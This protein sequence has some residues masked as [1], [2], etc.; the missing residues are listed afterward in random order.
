VMAKKP[1]LQSAMF[2]RFMTPLL[3]CSASD[4]GLTFVARLGN[5]NPPGTVP[6]PPAN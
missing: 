5:T 6:I 3:I 1:A 2:L 4:S